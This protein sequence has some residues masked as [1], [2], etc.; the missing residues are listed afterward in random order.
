MDTTEE[1]SM[2]GPPRYPDTGDDSGVAPDGGSTARRS[3]WVMVL[4]WIIGI[5]LVLGFLVL[6]LTGG[7]GPGTH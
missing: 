1:A 5:V 3:R 2:A 6:H 7:F 4:L